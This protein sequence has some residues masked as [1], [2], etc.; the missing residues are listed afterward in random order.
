MGITTIYDFFQEMVHFH[1]SFLLMFSKAM[2]RGSFFL[3]TCRSGKLSGDV[4]YTAL[5]RHHLVAALGLGPVHGVVGSPSTSRPVAPC[6][7]N[8]ATPK[9]QRDA[10]KHLAPMYYRKLRKFPPD[11]LGPLPDILRG[12][13]QDQDK[14]FSPIAAGHV[15][16]ARI[17]SARNF[18]RVRNRLSSRFVAMGVVEMLA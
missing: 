10:I 14:F 12:F 7:G 15:F 11:V 16:P 5:C 13:R 1:C 8:M 6:S 2:G 18:P 3:I 9:Q 17:R 4:G